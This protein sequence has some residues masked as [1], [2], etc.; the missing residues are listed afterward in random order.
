M[1]FLE[2]VEG[3]SMHQTKMSG[4]FETRNKLFNRLDDMTHEN[5][6]IDITIIYYFDL[7][8]ILYDHLA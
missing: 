5:F 7:M 1:L 3:Q 2:L 4:A 8:D 6:V